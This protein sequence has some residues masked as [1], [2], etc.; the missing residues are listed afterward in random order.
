MSGLIQP[1]GQACNSNACPA[2]LHWYGPLCVALV[3]TFAI[4]VTIDPTGV[5]PELAPGPGL[6]LDE[7]FNVETGVYQWRSFGEHGFS[8]WADPVREQVFGEASLYLPDHPPLGRLWIGAVHDFI[9]TFYPP[10]QVPASTVIA[11]ARFASAI[12]LGLTVFIV[13]LFAGRMY[14]PLASWIAPLSLCLMPRVFAHAHLAALE[15]CIGLAFTSTVLFIAWQWTR[16]PG[17]PTWTAAAI[18]GLIFGAAL[19]TKIQA[20]LLPLPIALWALWM[21]RGRTVPHLILFVA[22]AGIVF[23]IGWPWLWIDPVANVREYFARTTERP[24]LNCWYFGVQYA[25]TGVPWHYPFLMSAA[26][27]P[28][29]WLI[30]SGLGVAQSFRSWRAAQREDGDTTP[31]SA[32]ASLLVLLTI[33]FVLVFFALP[34]IP[35]YDGVRLFLVVFPLF[36]V[37]V[38][39]GAQ[40]FYSFCVERKLRWLCALFLTIA[41]LIPAWSMA[42]IHPL[43]LSYYSFSVGGLRGAERLGLERTYWRDS[44]TRSFARDVA[45]AVP[46]GATIDLAPVL[47]PR[48]EVDWL[49]QSPVLLE[50]DLQ[51]RS[52]RDDNLEQI[53]YV[54]VFRRRADPWDSLEPA[55]ARGV[56]LAEVERQGVQL[57]ALY[58]LSDTAESR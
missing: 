21:W 43:Q 52:Y 4:V 26:T 10:V 40:V 19:L 13:G 58:Q 34:G 30:L 6:T 3:S 53:E 57:A 47:H 36:A 33:G 54:L 46:R 27:V 24:T 38:G 45:E 16:K 2:G 23:L 15:T 39:Y 20:V 29:G 48:N 14:G 25:D 17:G 8:L 35:V 44:V 7:V 55:P 9:L 22:V 50:R 12:A 51:F 32:S 5:Y 18:A 31:V 56:L 1:A 37:L 28:L 41:C 49:S 11:S 42:S